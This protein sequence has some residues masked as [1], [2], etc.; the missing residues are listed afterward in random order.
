MAEKV[1]KNV[2][3]YI[4]KNNKTFQKIKHNRNFTNN[5]QK[6]KKKI[7]LQTIDVLFVCPLT[8]Y[9][10]SIS[11]DSKSTN[12]HWQKFWFLLPSLQLQDQE[13][14]DNLCWYIWQLLGLYLSDDDRPECHDHIYP[15][16]FPETVT[17]LPLNGIV[18]GIP[19]TSSVSLFEYWTY[20]QH[21]RS[22]PTFFF[23]H[24][25]FTFLTT[26]TSTSNFLE[27]ASN[28]LTSVVSLVISDPKLASALKII[29]TSSGL[30]SLLRIAS[31]WPPAIFIYILHW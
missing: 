29:Y 3:K 9:T 1:N 2:C 5:Y 25:L 21:W 19:T 6:K 17:N 15:P 13:F 11:P 8:F 4:T 26:A 20:F 7:Q 31:V 23:T 22:V 28:S 10:C 24:L 27:W 16:Q 30:L 14:E 18:P 12:S